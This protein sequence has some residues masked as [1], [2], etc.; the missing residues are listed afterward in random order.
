MP[1]RN[2]HAPTDETL[3]SQACAGCAESFEQLV[4]RYQTPLLQFLTRFGAGSHAEDLL[5]ETF[6]RAY[7]NLHRYR[8]G[9]RFA[10]W[11]FTI[12]RRL[13]I[14]HHHR[15]RSA[16]GGGLLEGLAAREPSPAQQAAEAD[17]RKRLW[18]VAETILSRDELAA[19][20]LFYVED[21]SAPEIAAV[22]ER[23]WVAVKTILFRA[24]RKL[25]KAFASHSLRD[26][27]APAARQRSNPALK[28]ETP[29]V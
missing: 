14:N 25:L 22:I 29:H 6:L 10:P 17:E 11:I 21:M 3:A 5:Q 27:L 8:P 2:S 20:W 23:S 4:R 1:S 9:E 24:R 19:L 12:A 28:M 13:G 26:D 16:D 7:R 15:E 18:R